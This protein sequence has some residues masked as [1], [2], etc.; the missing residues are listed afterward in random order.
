MMHLLIEH[1]DLEECRLLLEE[2]FQHSWLEL[3]IVVGYQENRFYSWLPDAPFSEEYCNRADRLFINYRIDTSYLQQRLLTA[4]LN[5]VSTFLSPVLDTLASRISQRLKDFKSGLNSGFPSYR[6]GQEKESIARSE[7]FKSAAEFL[8]L[9][10]STLE[11]P[12]TLSEAV[13]DAHFDEFYRGNAGL[14]DTLNLIKWNL[15]RTQFSEFRSK[16]HGLDLALQV[17][18]SGVPFGP[19]VVQHV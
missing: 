12:P 18:A 1:P 17:L 9:G 15:H 14:A 13:I 19:V 16:S 3:S 4:S 5:P 7:S 8:L 10:H 6:F 2:V 11:D